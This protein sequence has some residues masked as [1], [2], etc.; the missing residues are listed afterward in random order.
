[1]QEWSEGGIGVRGK[2]TKNRS[3][4]CG[5]GRGQFA[6]RKRSDDSNGNEAMGMTMACRGGGMMG[7]CRDEG[8]MNECT[9]GGMMVW[10]TPSSMMDWRNTEKEE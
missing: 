2:N 5:H 10:H 6:G 7:E 9:E 1:M 8:M 4:M 3:G